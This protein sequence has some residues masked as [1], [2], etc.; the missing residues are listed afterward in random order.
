MSS[1]GRTTQPTPRRARRA[2]ASDR[3]AMEVFRFDA[4]LDIILDRLEPLAREEVG[5]RGLAGR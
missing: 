4:S 2:A 3:R 5:H 1:P